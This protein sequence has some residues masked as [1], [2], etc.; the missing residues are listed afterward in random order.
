MVPALRL[1]CVDCLSADTEFKYSALT[2]NTT[3]LVISGS[4]GDGVDSDPCSA[5]GVQVTVTNIG[6]VDSDEV[7]QCY[8]KQP[9]ASTAPQVR[10]A[11]FA[12]VHIKAG[13]STTVSLSFGPKEQALVL[14][15]ASSGRGSSVYQP[16]MVVPAGAVE[17]HV[18]GGQP[19]FFEGA[20]MKTVTI[21]RTVNLTRSY[22][23]A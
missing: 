4:S 16:H 14:D 5:I 3:D 18:G 22:T 6:S 23:C 8:I 15:G 2:L 13:Q 11:D 21:Q 10:L 19:D 20:V 17:V 9:N 1:N 7:V 12:R